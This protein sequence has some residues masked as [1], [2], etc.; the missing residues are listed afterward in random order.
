MNPKIILKI[1]S[2]KILGDVNLKNILLRVTIIKY[3]MFERGERCV[4]CAR[5]AEMQ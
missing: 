4:H 1:Y 3:A 5:G 2:S